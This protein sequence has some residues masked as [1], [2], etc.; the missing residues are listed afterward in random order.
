MMGQQTGCRPP[1]S[2]MCHAEQRTMAN[3]SMPK[4]LWR[5]NGKTM[6]YHGRQE[7]RWPMEETD[8]DIV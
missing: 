7:G 8:G 1:P 2:M 3:S 5:G 4:E 6:P